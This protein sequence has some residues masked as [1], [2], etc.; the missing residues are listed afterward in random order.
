MA[1]SAPALAAQRGRH[2]PE[3][4]GHDESWPWSDVERESSVGYPPRHGYRSLNPIGRRESRA[5]NNRLPR[6]R[7]EEQG[8][9]AGADTR[10][11]Q[12]RASACAW[13]SPVRTATNG[14]QRGRTVQT[15]NGRIPPGVPFR[16]AAHACRTAPSPVCRKRPLTTHADQQQHAEELDMLSARVT[17][18]AQLVTDFARLHEQH[19]ATLQAQLAAAGRASGALDGAVRTHRRELQDARRVV[20]ARRPDPDSAAHREDAGVV[21]PE[22]LGERRTRGRRLYCFV[23]AND[24]DTEAFAFT[25]RPRTH[26]KRAVARKPW[27]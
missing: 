10:P 26:F 3:P 19:A 6:G 20:G 16:L 2:S 25:T 7:Q 9:N 22:P 1:A 18:L 21:R 15:R 14:S 27:H 23:L 8:A 24:V 11:A 13:P 4:G 12:R 17:D 5:A